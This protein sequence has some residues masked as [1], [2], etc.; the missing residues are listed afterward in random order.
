MTIKEV[1]EID[2][3]DKN[4]IIIGCPA[5]GKTWLSNKIKSENHN[6]IHTDDYIKH[7]YEQS[8]YEALK[9]IEISEKK[10]IVEG[11]QG[12]RMLRKGLELGSYFPDI[13]IEIIVPFQQV[14]AIYKLERDEDKI[15]KLQSMIK[16]NDKVLN[17]YKA[18]KNE[19]APEWITIN[20]ERNIYEDV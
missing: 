13:V 16:S 12:Y 15:P 14:V 17:D 10:T 19:H 7:G 8:M 3:M 6:V 20:N 2:F 5:S 11:V 1:L 18:M 9:D 4:V